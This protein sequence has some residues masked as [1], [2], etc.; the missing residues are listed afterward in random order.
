MFRALWILS[1]FLGASTD[2]PISVHK[3]PPTTQFV[4]FDPAHPPANAPRLSPN[5][6]AA[7]RMLFNCTVHVK[8]DVIRKEVRGGKWQIEARLQQ[9]EVTLD[10]TDS[11]FLPKG[12]NQKLKN[13]ELGHA[14][15]NE[16]TFS[17][18]AATAAKRA[19]EEVRGKTWKGSGN[20]LDSAGKN[21]TDAAV[22][23][24]CDSYLKATA[25]KAFRIGEIYDDLTDHGTRASPN[26]DDAIKQAVE[27][28]ARETKK[29]SS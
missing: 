14:R 2:N 1:L 11:I 9:V 12:A 20:S 6:S 25:D 5:E 21:A 13:H 10:L 23:A 8:Y 26:E 3:N 7:T 28:Q 24:L 16:I 15:I 17:E 19:A 22:N 29:V 18:D 4:E 27:K